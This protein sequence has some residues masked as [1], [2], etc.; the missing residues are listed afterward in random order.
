[1][2]AGRILAKLLAPYK[3]GDTVVLG[4]PRGGLPVAY[5]V[6]EALG[7]PL[8]V[9]VS[10]KLAAPWHPEFGFGAVAGDVVVVD[11]ES[12]RLLGL[13]EVQIEQIVERERKE[14][15]RREALFRAGRGPLRLRGRTVVL[16]DD[17]LATG[18]TAEAACDAVRK[19][20]PAR[21]VLAVPVCA[22]DSAE[23]LR[24]HAD[25][26]VCAFVPPAFAA[27]GQFYADFR[28]TEDSDVIELLRRRRGPVAHEDLPPRRPGE[29][30][31][32][33]ESF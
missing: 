11:Q 24:A 33:D 15:A 17:G 9:L 4:L 29:E 31:P 22:A 7:A 25:E 19:E 21:L 12:V 26:V 14:A 1:M 23:R 28:Q 13:D 6:A 8:D 3:G 5:Q 32:H 16:V 20:G 30:R 27:V 18:V 2:D 10:R